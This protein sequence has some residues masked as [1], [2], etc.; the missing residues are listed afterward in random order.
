MSCLFVECLGLLPPWI[1]KKN[2]SKC[3]HHLAIRFY[4]IWIWDGE[5]A[6]MFLVTLFFAKPGQSHPQPASPS[7]TLPP[8][9]MPSLQLSSDLEQAAAWRLAGRALGGASEL[10]LA[11][12]RDCTA[13]SPSNLFT[14]LYLHPLALVTS[15]LARYLCG[16][17]HY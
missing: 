2:V 6:D 17:S 15:L 7:S 12:C 8:Q 11:R 14:S 13:M 3:L 10:V 9:R 4:V 1:F 16:T 5:I